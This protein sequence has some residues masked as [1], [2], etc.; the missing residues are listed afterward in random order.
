MYTLSRPVQYRTA[1]LVL[2][3]GYAAVLVLVLVHVDWYSWYTGTVQRSRRW[4]AA[5]G[6]VPASGCSV[7]S[8]RAYSTEYTRVQVSRYYS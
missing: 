6:A 8:V 2:V 4:P 7:A 5:A 1:V 3:R